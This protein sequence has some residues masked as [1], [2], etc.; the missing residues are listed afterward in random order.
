M[1]NSKKLFVAFFLLVITISCQ[2]ETAVPSVSPT[3]T[4]PV[5]N[6]GNPAPTVIDNILDFT[7]TSDINT[8]VSLSDFKDKVVVLFFFGNGCT[9]CKAVSPDVQSTFVTNYANKKVQVIGLDAWD[10][11]LSS[12]QSFKKSSDLTF[13]LLLSASGV[14]KTFETTYDRLIV[15]DKKG[16]V[17]FKGAQ[18]ARND[19]SNAKK[20][21]DEYLSK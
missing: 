2:V 17:Q 6:S 4:P 3:T 21:V 10:G 11:N 16:I 20:V 14:A 1:T 9:S 19:I 8:K 7:L 18:L 5:T 13:P 12:V 15:V